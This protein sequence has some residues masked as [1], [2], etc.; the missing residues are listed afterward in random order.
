MSMWK[1]K[2][3]IDQSKPVKRSSQEIDPAKLDSYDSPPIKP[4]MSAQQ[5]VQ[6]VATQH[7]SNNVALVNGPEKEENNE[8]APPF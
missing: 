1:K 4:K 5:D 2:A 6:P 8:S 7:A 3:A